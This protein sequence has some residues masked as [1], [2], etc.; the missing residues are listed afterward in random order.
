M[1]KPRRRW[2]AGLGV[3]GVGGVLILSLPPSTAARGGLVD[4]GLAGGEGGEQGL[5][6]E[7]VDGA[8]V[9]AAGPVDQG[10][11]SSENRVSERSA[12]ARWRR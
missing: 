6:G 1:R 12:R 7:V 11:A 3:R 9:A 8:G 5:D 10:G 2:P 4:D